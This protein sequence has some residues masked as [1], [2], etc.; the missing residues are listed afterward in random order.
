MKDKRFFF[1]V[2]APKAGTYSL[3]EA[4]KCHPN[5]SMTRVKEPN[6]FV[7]TENNADNMRMVK[8]HVEYE[9]LW[10]LTCSNKI[11]FGEASPSYLR[12]KESPALIKAKYPRAK[13]F[14]VIRNPV[15]RAFS[16][17]KMDV[18]QGHQKD[19]FRS[20]FLRDYN[21]K[22]GMKIQ[23]EYYKSGLY[24][25]GIKRYQ[26]IFGDDNVTVYKFEDLSRDFNR[27]L[28]SITDSLELPRSSGANIKH[29]NEA[30]RA[31]NKLLL[32]IYQNK[33]IKKTIG[34]ALGEDFR[35]YLKSIIFSGEPDRD[36]LSYD[37][38]AYFFDYFRGD[39]EETEK[40]LGLDLK[41]WHESK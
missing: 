2:G 3:Y 17:W 4:L 10:N 14:I 11:A 24:C 1:I 21:D 39:V 34:R 12:C 7:V 15:D 28:L 5:I 35:R 27:I 38:F 16:N 29:E 20:S 18:R 30:R 22:G 26:N 25:E 40:L 8:S 9:N 13:I 23:Y 41:S 36:R 37:D 31:K 32:A 6:Y 33:M 19:D